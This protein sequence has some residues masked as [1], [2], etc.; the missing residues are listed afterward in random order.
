MDRSIYCLTVEEAYPDYKRPKVELKVSHWVF[1]SDAKAEAQAAVK[2]YVSYHDVC[3]KAYNKGDIYDKVYTDG[4][5][6]Q[7]PIKVTILQLDC[8]SPGDIEQQTVDYKVVLDEKDC[9][10]SVCT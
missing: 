3:V 4:Y 9:S 5:L 8:V 10:C 2:R 1:L 7:E 6:D